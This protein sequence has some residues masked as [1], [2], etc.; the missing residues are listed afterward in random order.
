MMDEAELEA[1]RGQL[2]DGKVQI[3]CFVAHRRPTWVI[4]WEEHFHPDYGVQLDALLKKPGLEAHLPKGLSLDAY[5]AKVA[6]DYRG[7]MLRLTRD[8]LQAYFALPEVLTPDREDMRRLYHGALTE[9][10]PAALAGLARYFETGTEAPWA[11]EHPRAAACLP[12]FF[13]DFDRR[14]M[15]HRRRERMFEDALPP[16]WTGAMGCFADLV[17]QAEQY[18]LTPDAGPEA[19]PQAGGAA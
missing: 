17:P 12:A 8:D 9:G 18:W 19:G 3:A 11:E 10:S 1:L 7:G 4:D 16:D 6:A 5:E 13:L 15:R 2:V 14:L